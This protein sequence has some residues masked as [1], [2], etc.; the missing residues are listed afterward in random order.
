MMK[1][2]L[3]Q[4]RCDK[5]AA[6]ILVALSMVAVVSAVAIAVDIGMLVTARTAAQRAADSAALAGASAFIDD[7][8]NA[9]TLAPARAEDYA[10]RHNVGTQTVNLVPAE[11]VEVLLAERKVRVTVRHLRTRNNAIQTFFARVFGIDLVDVQAMAAAEAVPADQVGCLAPWAVGD[12]WDDNWPSGP[13]EPDEFDYDDPDRSDTPTPGDSFDN[14]CPCARDDS[15]GNITVDQDYINNGYG[16]IV[17]WDQSTGCTGYGSE[18][19]DNDGMGIQNDVGRMLT[20]KPG[21]PAQSW[22]PGWFMAWRP[23]GD[24]GGNDYRQNIIDCIDGQAFSD[25][26][27]VPVDTEQGNMIGPTVQGVEER[28]GDDQHEW[29][30]GC[31]GGTECIQGPECGYGTYGECTDY[32]R[33]LIIVPLMDPSEHMRNGLTEIQFRGFMR[34]F[35]NDPQGNDITG[36]ILGLG[37]AAGDG[38]LDTDTGALPL[39]LRL[40]E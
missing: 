36:H 7:A 29:R 26:S 40:V 13:T 19:R 24:S 32:S 25:N 6:F 16:N 15:N 2:V 9:S 17:C 21:N 31:V 34:L 33:R 10:E 22:S 27:I 14:Y 11:D 5:G 1:R 23:P 20:L 30:D 28:I 39:Y 8:E 12:A 18:F 38:G 4:A 37:G 3:R 35:L